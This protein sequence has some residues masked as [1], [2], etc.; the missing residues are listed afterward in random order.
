MTFLKSCACL[1][2]LDSEK[3]NIIMFFLHEGLTFWGVFRAD[4]V[5]VNHAVSGTSIG[6]RTYIPK[7]HTENLKLEYMSKLCTGFLIVLINIS[8]IL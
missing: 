2:I 3:C 1:L 8:K 4:N 6:C 5:H 7:S